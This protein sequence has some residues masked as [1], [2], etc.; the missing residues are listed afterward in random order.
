MGHEGEIW[1]E[2]RFKA[3]FWGAASPPS[4]AF[5]AHNRLRQKASQ[6]RQTAYKSALA[7]HRKFRDWTYVI[8]SQCLYKTRFAE[9]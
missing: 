1:C 8:C 2:A 4:P 7:Q 9:K 3:F 5:R 6:R